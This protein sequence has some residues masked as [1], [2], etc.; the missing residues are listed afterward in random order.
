MCSFDM[1]EMECVWER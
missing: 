1:S